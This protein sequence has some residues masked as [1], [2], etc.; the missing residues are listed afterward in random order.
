MVIAAVFSS[1]GNYKEVICLILNISAQSLKITS[2][3]SSPVK[4]RAGSDLTLDIKYEYTGSKTVGVTWRRG[5]TILIRKLL[6]GTIQ[7]FD[8]RASLKNDLSL[9]LKN[10]TINDN[11]TFEVSL[12]AQDVLTEP[13]EKINVF[14]EG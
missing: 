3:P 12:R 4:L 10:V 8:N 14:A 13:V 7:S 2:T 9:I 5:S 1:L 6:T 11:A